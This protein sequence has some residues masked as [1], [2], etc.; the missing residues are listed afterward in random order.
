MAARREVTSHPLDNPLWSSLS[1]LHRSLALGVAERELLRYPADVA[2][3]LATAARAPLSDDALSLL[4]A[5]GETVFLVGP[6]PDVPRGFRLD[7]LGPLHQM[8]CERALPEADGP[9]IVPLL[10]EHRPAVLALTALVYPH[11]F[12]PRTTSLGR[13]FGIFEGD[14]L[15]AMIGERMGMPGFREISAVC[16][17]PDFT[18]RG[19]ARRLLAFLGNDIL[20]SGR[21][22]F[23]HVSPTNERA[24]LLYEQNGYTTRIMISFWSLRRA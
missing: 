17:H 5:D 13:Y 7:A 10:E 24:R 19:L 23:L 18:G 20:A 8:T 2:P 9:A 14:R 1:T 6:R 15:A 4:V 16:T 11:Y 21:T 3:F 22:P 12:R